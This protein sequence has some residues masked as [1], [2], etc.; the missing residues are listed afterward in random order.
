MTNGT[1]TIT[2][3][4]CQIVSLTL[5]LEAGS[6]GY[7]YGVPWQFIPGLWPSANSQLWFGNYSFVPG[8]TTAANGFSKWSSDITY[9]WDDIHAVIHNWDSINVGDK[10]TVTIVHMPTSQVIWKGDVEVMP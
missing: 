10:V 8:N 1:Y 5:K 3:D 2:S 9:L 7:Y 6:Y 4:Q